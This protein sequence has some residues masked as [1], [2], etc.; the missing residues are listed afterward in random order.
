MKQKVSEIVKQIYSSVPV[1]ERDKRND[2]IHHYNILKQWRKFSRKS[3]QEDATTPSLTEPDDSTVTF[4][5]Q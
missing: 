3:D 5:Q 2:A 4:G 1:S